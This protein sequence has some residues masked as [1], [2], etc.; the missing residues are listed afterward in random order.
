MNL[1]IK[2]IFIVLFLFCATINAQTEVTVKGTVTSQSDG[3]PILGANVIIV[4]TKKGTSTDFDGNYE[5]KVKQGEIIEVSY[6]GFKSKKVPFVNQKTINVSLEEDSNVLD[7]IVVIGYGTQKKSHLTGAISK[8]KNDDLD[9]IAVSR[10]DDAL[11][12]QV[13]GVNIQATDGEAGAA[14]T[15]TIRGI[16]SMAGDST[17]LIVVDGVIVDS[18][19]LGSL[20]M[21]DVE[22]FEILKDAASS[23]IYG[24]KGSN[25]IIMIS[26]KSGVEGKTKINYST[27]TGYKSGRKSSAYGYTTQGWADQQIAAGNALS[28]YTQAQLQTGTDR[29]WQDVFIDGGTITSHSISFRGGD[30]KTKF[31]LSASRKKEEGIIKNTGFERNSISLSVK[32][33]LSVMVVALRLIMESRSINRP[34]SG[35]KVLPL[36]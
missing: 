18:D 9:Q 22:S 29:S 10:V 35:S 33:D 25:G 26:M 8:V 13:S 12:G 11:V 32:P 21:N 31:Y 28:V 17:P 14:P 6:L 15:I 24:S 7:E 5:I 23:S 19:F 20:N 2:S 27:Y 3:E 30:D 16:G 36:T 34:L 4:G 1:K